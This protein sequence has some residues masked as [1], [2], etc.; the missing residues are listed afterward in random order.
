MGRI[1]VV[2][3]SACDIPQAEVERYGITI[4]PLV[5]VFGEEDYPDRTL[6]PEE[7]WAKAAQVHPQ[8]SQPSP[9]AFAAAYR[10]IIEAGDDVFCIT[11][12]GKHSGTYNSALAAAAE[13]PPGR[14]TVFDSLSLS[15]GQGVQVVAAARL[16]EEGASAEEIAAHLRELQTRIH[17]LILLDTVEYLE[18]GGRAAALM[19]LVKRVA[20]ALSIKPILNLVEGEL[21]LVSAVRSYERGLERL[22]REAAARAPWETAGVLHARAFQAAETVADRLAQATGFPRGDIL[23][24]ETGSVLSSHGG[25]GVL[26]VIIVS[27][28]PS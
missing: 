25:P 4:V 6:S 7:Y 17:I 16:A 1:R 2:T 5:V 18:R 26:G 3:D 24:M 12:T 11:I 20:R 8:T 10:P 27:Q 13:F 21:K 19:P 28:K 14:V 15:Q 9:G 22:V 23:V